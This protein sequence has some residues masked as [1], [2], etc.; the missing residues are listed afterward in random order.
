MR[1]VK[2]FVTVTIYFPKEIFVTKLDPSFYSQI[3]EILLSARNKVYATANF[4]M[5]EA[6]EKASQSP[7]CRICDCFI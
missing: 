4:A 6:S 1:S 3:K 5:V 7:I 2:D